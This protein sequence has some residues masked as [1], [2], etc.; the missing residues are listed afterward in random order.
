MERQRDVPRSASGVD[1]KHKILK[2][3]GVLSKQ[4]KPPGEGNISRD[5]TGDILDIRL[6]SQQGKRWNL[7][8]RQKI[9]PKY[10]G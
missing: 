8:G 9:I 6:T 4:T 5:V 3:L 1:R 10:C 7:G 2:V